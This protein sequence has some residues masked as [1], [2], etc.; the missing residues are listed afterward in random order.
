MTA[1]SSI[2]A[3]AAAP[4]AGV[5]AAAAVLALVARS[6]ANNAIFKRVKRN[7]DGR[8]VI[9]KVKNPTGTQSS[10]PA[11]LGP[12][13]FKTVSGTNSS[14]TVSGSKSF[15][16]VSGTRSSKTVSGT[17]S[18]KTVSS[19]NSSR[20]KAAASADSDEPLFDFSTLG[21]WGLGLVTAVSV[22]PVCST[23]VFLLSD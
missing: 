9:K 2:D 1:A 15:R 21:V 16:T 3:A 13:L 8:R 10:E 14:R 11:G 22:R 19:T 12:Q 23:T 5:L 7:K 17:K 6:A 18:S 20:A 4:A